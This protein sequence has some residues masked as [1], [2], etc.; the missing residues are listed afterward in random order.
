MH[1]L[2]S[3]IFGYGNETNLQLAVWL[4]DALEVQ[5]PIANINVELKL[6]EVPGKVLAGSL[7]DL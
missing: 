5:R 1:Q 4:Y 7:P 2:G 3:G 6:V